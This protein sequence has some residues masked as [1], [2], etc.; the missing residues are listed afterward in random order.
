MKIESGKTRGPFKGTVYG[1]Q[2][3][4]KTTW[5]KDSPNPLFLAP[6]SG[7]DQ[8]DVSRVRFNSWEELLINVASEDVEQFE[9]LVIDELGAVET[10]LWDHLCNKNDWE[11]I[12]TP[13]WGDGYKAAG[14]EFQNFLALL[15]RTR[16]NVIFTAH[17]EVDNK[18]DN[19]EGKDYARYDV[20]VH[21][22]LKSALWK[23]SDFQL[24]L[25]VPVSAVDISEKGD[26]KTKI[27][28]TAEG[29]Y[30]LHAQS[31]PTLAA[32]NRYNCKPT[33]SRKNGFREFQLY[34]DGTFMSDEELE[35]AIKGSK[36][37]KPELSEQQ[38]VQLYVH[39]NL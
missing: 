26:R 19:P 20:A 23:W 33:L 10:M 2:G 18:R 16:K 11:H 7:T 8:L 12:G 9:T 32:K 15:D 21:K 37:F 3:V 34:I 4:G 14:M 28:G 22:Y 25:R 31:T 1:E 30:V 24:F 5:T 29:E 17:A 13:D 27:I 35:E 36:Y 38:R 6:T 39:I